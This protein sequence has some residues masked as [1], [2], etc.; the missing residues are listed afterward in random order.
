MNKIK[1]WVFY[2]FTSGCLTAIIVC[3]ICDYFQPTTGEISWSALV[4]LSLV[5]SWIMS[6]PL[7]KGR[8]KTVKNMLIVTSIVIVSFLAG[9]SIILK[10]PIILKMGSCIAVLSVA[11]VWGIYAVFFK[12]KKRVFLALA[13]SLIVTVPLACGITHICAYFIED[14]QKDL[15]SDFFH[16]I[17][18]LALSGFC[19]IV[20]YIKVHSDNYRE[21]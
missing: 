13:F 5:T 2:A 21:D 3:V 6:L 11:A 16:V 14:I 17:I 9:I 8:N 18:T 19:L 15:A 10:L 1:K 7:F 20:D 4:V 12:Y